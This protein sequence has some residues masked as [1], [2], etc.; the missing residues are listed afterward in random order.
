MGYRSDVAY[1]VKFHD[2]KQPEKVF[3]DYIAFQDWVKNKHTVAYNDPDLATQTEIKHEHTYVEEVNLIRWSH[4]E[5]LMAFQVDDVK[6]Y[7]SFGDVRWHI[8]LLEKVKEYDTGNYRFVRLGED[9]NDVEVEE[10]AET[11]F[12]LWELLDVH[13]SYAL[14][15]P[16]DDFDKEKDDE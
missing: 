4:K 16:N 8:K 10:H 5:S 3:A 12:E 15:V 11:Y 2:E 7:E 14:N 6:W 9:Y 13:R 1:I